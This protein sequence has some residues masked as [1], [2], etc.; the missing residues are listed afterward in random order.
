MILTRRI[1][2]LA[3]NYDHSY[4]TILGEP[5]AEL[6]PIKNITRGGCDKN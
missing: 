2:K 5:L 1:T 6:K 4:E 3:T